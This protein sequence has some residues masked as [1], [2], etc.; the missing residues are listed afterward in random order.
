MTRAKHDRREA[1]DRHRPPTWAGVVLVVTLAPVLLAP[2]CIE[3]EPA[4]VPDVGPVDSGPEDSGPE[5]GGPSDAE[6]MDAMMSLP[7]AVGPTV[8]PAVPCPSP[9]QAFF[10]IQN[11][12]YIIEC[13][14][15]EADGKVCTINLGTEVIWNFADAVEH[16]VSSLEHAFG[17]SNDRLS[18]VFSSSFEVAGDFGY[19]CSLHP[20]AMS[21]YSIVVVE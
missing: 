3:Y 16:N 10:T 14:C 5:D 9:G 7:D 21:G 20:R 6:P 18:G 2:K 17:Q 8:T 4:A 19:G 11:F 15:A 1:S 12:E 13:G